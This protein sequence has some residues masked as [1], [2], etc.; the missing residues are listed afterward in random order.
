MKLSRNLLFAVIVILVVGGC[1]KPKALVPT[2]YVPF[3]AS[4]SAFTCDAP[5]GWTSSSFASTGTESGG[6]FS[7]ASADIHVDSDEAGSF[8]GDI[9]A[10]GGVGTVIAGGATQSPIPPVEKL[11]ATQGADFANRLHNYVELGTNNTTAPYGDGRVTEY[12]ADGIHGY[13]VTILGRERSVT[14]D[15]NCPEDE[16]PAL[17]AMF[18]HV[19]NSIQAGS[20]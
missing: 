7:S 4:D 1:T 13:R 2:S 11:H 16:W 12:T 18:L 14:V 19:I 10:S 15:A 5:A 17:N 8:M 20:S 3:K 6:D 9:A